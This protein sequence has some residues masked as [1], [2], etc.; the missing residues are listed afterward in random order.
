LDDDWLL[1]NNRLIKA[2]DGLIRAWYTADQIDYYPVTNSSYWFEWRLWGMHSAGYH[3][4]NLALHI[5][6]ALLIGTILS[7][8]SVPGAFLAALLFALHPVNVE[9]V[10]WVAQR[11]TLLAMLFLLLSALWYLKADVETV[12]HHRD[13]ATAARWHWLSLAAFVLAMLS[14]G[15]AAP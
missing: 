10:A 14:K 8:L 9:T 11:K 5:S 13:A 2:S 12:H 1:T 6:E 7:A 15:S 3:V 4:T